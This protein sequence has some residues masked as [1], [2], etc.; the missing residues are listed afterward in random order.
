MCL[1][2]LRYIEYYSHVRTEET[3][4]AT[5][6]IE[7]YL[8]ERNVPFEIIDHSHSATS[9]QTAHAAKLDAS[10]L[11]KAVLLEGED[12]VLAA[13]IPADQE[14]RLGHL[15]QDFGEHIHLADEATVRRTF[16]DCDPG[17]MPGLPIVWG[18]ETVWDDDLLAQPDIYLETGDHQRLIHVETRRLQM[19]LDEMPHCHFC[20][21]RKAH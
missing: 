6:R 7:S 11:A 3:M 18:V 21:P 20:G 5:H 16:T 15:K 2:V 17:A 14:V 4:N 8:K 1:R 12:C 9:L 19:V 10:R 13:L